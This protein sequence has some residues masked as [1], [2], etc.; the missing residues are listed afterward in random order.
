MR[1]SEQ[2]CQKFQHGINILSKRWMG[3]IVKVLLD[4]PLRFH[5]MKSQIQWISDRVLSE[6]LKEL[7]DEGIV[8]RRVY[9]ETPVRVEYRLTD[10][11]KALAPVIAAVEHWSESWVGQG[12]AEN[13]APSGHIQTFETVPHLSEG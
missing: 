11:G 8:E 3:L 4:G 5:E 6:R 7:E 9:A 13:E 12:S 1:Y 2:I 10:K